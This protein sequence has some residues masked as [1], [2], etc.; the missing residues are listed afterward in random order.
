MIS[1]YAI[2]FVIDRLC[3][4]LLLNAASIRYKLKLC[5]LVTFVFGRRLY[6][7]HI[8][9]F[10]TC[11]DSDFKATDR[12]QYYYQ[13][14]HA[15]RPRFERKTKSSKSRRD[16]IFSRRSTRISASASRHKTRHAAVS[17]YHLYVSDWQDYYYF[18][19][20]T[21]HR[22]ASVEFMSGRNEFRAEKRFFP[23]LFA[24][25]YNLIAAAAMEPERGAG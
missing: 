25:T 4:K 12:N 17:D 5:F 15:S 10:G 16:K 21:S 8:L 7:S 23:V 20:Y 24:R 3:P 13:R 9:L 1:P 14:S 6:I 2:K 18:F 22:T 11:R 19:L